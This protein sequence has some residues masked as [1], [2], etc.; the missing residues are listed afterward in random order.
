[1]TAEALTALPERGDPRRT[2]HLN[3]LLRLTANNDPAHVTFVRGPREW[4]GDHAIAT[5]LA[6]RWDGV[7]Y[8]RPGAKLVFETIAPALVAL[9]QATRWAAPRISAGRV[10]T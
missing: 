2:D 5:D 9:P 6:Y 1:M 7:H 4:C 3:H 8:Y 10:A